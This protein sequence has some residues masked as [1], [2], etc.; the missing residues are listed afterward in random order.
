[1]KAAVRPEVAVA[2]VEGAKRSKVAVVPGERCRW[3]RGAGERCMWVVVGRS[4]NAVSVAHTVW[5][6]VRTRVRA[7]QTLES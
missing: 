7:A 2:A 5:T 1:M 4:T 6:M 3:C